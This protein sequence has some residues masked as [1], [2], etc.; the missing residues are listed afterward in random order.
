MI[1][2][3]MIVGDNMPENVPKYVSIAMS[4]TQAIASVNPYEKKVRI[5]SCS[6]SNSCQQRGLLRK[7][8]LPTCG[9]VVSAKR[10]SQG[11]RIRAEINEV[12]PEELEQITQN[13]HPHSRER[14]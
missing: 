8:C 10:F 1:I 4:N 3:I 2:I 11:R 7:G 13:T 6:N 9:A 14:L 12:N 5:V